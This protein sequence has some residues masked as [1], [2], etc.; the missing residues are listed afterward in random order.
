MSWSLLRRPKRCYCSLSLPFDILLGGRNMKV[1]AYLKLEIGSVSWECSCWYQ[2]TGVTVW[3]WSLGSSMDLWYLKVFLG[4]SV[5][6]PEF[7]FRLEHRLGPWNLGLMRS[8]W[9]HDNM[10][11]R[12][13]YYK[14]ENNN[15]PVDNQL[16]LRSWST[17]ST[18]KST[19]TR[20]NSADS[21]LNYLPNLE[22]INIE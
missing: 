7:I 16:I 5:S 8:L 21:S 19:H 4:H 17:L 18:I 13:R 9:E 14:R 15:N 12:L 6:K 20:K 22:F 1:A 10:V 2:L 3:R 11:V